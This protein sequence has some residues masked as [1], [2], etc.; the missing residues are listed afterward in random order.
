[1]CFKGDRISHL[2]LQRL[3][4]SL[5]YQASSCIGR[6]NKLEVFPTSDM[7]AVPSLQREQCAQADKCT[8]VQHSHA[9]VI[10]NNLVWVFRLQEDNNAEWIGQ[11]EALFAAILQALCIIDRSTGVNSKLRIALAEIILCTVSS[12]QRLTWL[13]V[14]EGL[15]SHVHYEILLVHKTRCMLWALRVVCTWYEL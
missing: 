15:L 7:F 1:M 13:T 2:G 12:L 14:K 9:L 4:K 11:Q 3:C 5:F 8:L 10:L 6:F